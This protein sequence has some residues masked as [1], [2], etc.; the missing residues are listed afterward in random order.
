MNAP[1][2]LPAAANGATAGDEIT[3]RDALAYEYEPADAVP[4]SGGRRSGAAMRLTRQS[5]EPDRPGPPTAVLESLTSRY[6]LDGLA[7]HAARYAALRP[8]QDVA[9]TLPAGAFGARIEDAEGQPLPFDRSNGKT[10]RVRAESLAGVPAIVVRYT[11]GAGAPEAGRHISPSVPQRPTPPDVVRWNVRLPAEFAVAGPGESHR[12]S[13]RVLG[14]L[15]PSRWPTAASGPRSSS[16]SIIVG[17]DRGGFLRVVSPRRRLQRELVALCV[18][19]VAAALLVGF[20]REAWWLMTGG[21]LAAALVLPADAAMVASSIW[22][23]GLLGPPLRLV[24]AWLTARSATAGSTAS[25]SLESQTTAARRIMIP[26]IVLAVAAAGSAG[27][28]KPPQPLLVPVDESGDRV[29]EKVY[30]PEPLLEQLLARD[31][32]RRRPEP[33]GVLVRSAQY[34][35]AMARGG[36]GSLVVRDWTARLEI[37][38]F[39]R[40]ARVRLPLRRGDADWPDAVLVDGEPRRLEWNADGDECAFD[41]DRPGDAIAV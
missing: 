39:A 29:G 35:G 13:D 18:A 5:V 21:G 23:G 14:V 17:T 16:V 11:S 37:T 20:R 12:F 10:I 41:V 33:S 6:G 24:V 26:T 32:A 31:A 36:D 8:G 30:V 1:G 9:I 2:L 15:N 25:D 40:G 3:D 38:T 19:M 27:A 22:L 28:A 34:R 7:R 4:R